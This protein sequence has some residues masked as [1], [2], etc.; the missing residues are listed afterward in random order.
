MEKDGVCST[1]YKAGKITSQKA[2]FVCQ[3][4]QVCALQKDLCKQHLPQPKTRC[5]LHFRRTQTDVGIHGFFF[6]AEQFLSL[7]LCCSI[8]IYRVAAKLNTS[9]YQTKVK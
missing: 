3:T 5:V 4:Q 9:V 2:A 1:F 8:I 7:A 6:V